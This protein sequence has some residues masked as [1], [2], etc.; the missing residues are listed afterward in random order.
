L[1][2]LVGDNLR[3]ASALALNDFA[4]EFSDLGLRP[5]L[6][7]MLATV[8]QHAGISATE[9]C[10][11]LGIRRANM[12]PLI[13]ELEQQGLTERVSDAADRRV[14]R[15]YL[16]ARARRVVP[17]LQLRIRQHEDSLLHSLTRPERAVLL[18]LLQR[19]WMDEEQRG[20]AFTQTSFIAMPP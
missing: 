17:R 20:L 2:D 7:G 6:Y 10:R 4:V 5:V 11:V 9:L 3:R 13:T 15:L 8:A 18:Q 1:E 12:V 19:I 14:Q 16:S